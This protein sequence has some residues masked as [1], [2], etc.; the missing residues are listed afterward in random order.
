MSQKKC[1]GIEHTIQKGDTLYVLSRK[2]RVPLSFIMR[3]NPYVDVYNL[4]VGTQICIPC[5][6]NIQVD[7]V[8]QEGI[9]NNQTVNQVE[10]EVE[11]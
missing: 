8:T 4:Q 7:G 2:Y 10:L 6:S 1:F 11:A 9:I 3:A 5:H